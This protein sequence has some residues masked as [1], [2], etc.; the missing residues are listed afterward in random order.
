MSDSAALIS[1]LLLGLFRPKRKIP[2]HEFSGE[3]ELFVIEITTFKVGDEVFGTT[4][5][6]KQGSYAEYISVPREW[7][8]GVIDFNPIGFES[9]VIC[10][11]AYQW[12]DNTLLV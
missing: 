11:T 4:T 8:H 10:C 6:L 3:I 1:S 7:K 12:H 2:G 9:S 5:F